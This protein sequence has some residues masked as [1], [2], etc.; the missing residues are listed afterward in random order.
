MKTELFDKLVE[1]IHEGAKILY[2]ASK[3]SRSFEIK[4]NE[5]KEIRLKHNLLQI[6]FAEQLG[7]SVGTLKNWEQGRRKL[8]GPANVLLAIADRNPEVVFKNI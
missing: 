6:Q 2:G 1:S 5:I 3:P 7:I 4:S 8:T